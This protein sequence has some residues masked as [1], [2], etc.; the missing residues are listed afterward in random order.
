M[1]RIDDLI[2]R[3]EEIDEDLAGELAREVGV[4][5]HA[6]RVRAAEEHLRATIGEFAY[7]MTGQDGELEIDAAARDLIDA[8]DAKLKYEDPDRWAEMQRGCG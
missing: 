8:R 4:L 1:D 7:D 5:R 2:S 6:R 3:V